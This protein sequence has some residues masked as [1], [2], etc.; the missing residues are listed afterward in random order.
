MQTEIKQL[1]DT[2]TS[3]RR[4]E[5]EEIPRE[6]MDTIYAAIRNSPTSYNGQQFSV[7]DI[8][9]QDI[10]LKLYE[11]TNQ[12]QIKTCNHFMMFCA[13][14]NK[15][16]KLAEYK[17]IDVPAFNETLDCVMIGIIDAS[18]AMQSAVIAAQACGLGSC[19]V[20][21]A[22]TANPSLIAEVL[23][24]PKGVFAV[25]GLAIGVPREHPDLKP[26]MPEALVI[27]KDHYRSDDMGPDLAKY[28]A[29]V[30]EYN[31]TRSG[32]KTDNDWC[33]HILDYYEEA[34]KYN[35]LDYI[36]TQGFDV[37]K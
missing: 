16:H 33:K 36:K 37:K 21:Y 27:H 17:G 22:R 20:G 15:I 19:C 3:V 12:K 24:L 10:K 6:A 25:C 7:I 35:M 32:T 18:I 8:T 2:R 28:D 26:K 9:N 1:F 14:Y 4:Y 23:Q 31:M 13:D 29:T 5:R 34:M 11:I 30:S